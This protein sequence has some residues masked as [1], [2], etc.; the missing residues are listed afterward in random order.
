MKFFYLCNVFVYIHDMMKF[1]QKNDDT[2][3]DFVI[4]DNNVCL[5]EKDYYKFFLLV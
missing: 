4:L 2:L 3:L 1:F 5:Y